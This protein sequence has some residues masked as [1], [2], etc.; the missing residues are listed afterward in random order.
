[1][2]IGARLGASHRKARLA[3]IC[4]HQRARLGAP[5]IAPQCRQS[6]LRS[7]DAPAVARSEEPI[8]C[9]IAT[10]D[11]SCCKRGVHAT[12]FSDSPRCGSEFAR[13][14]ASF[15]FQ[16]GLS[17]LA[18]VSCRAGSYAGMWP[19]QQPHLSQPSISVSPSSSHSVLH[20]GQYSPV[21]T[22]QAEQTK[23]GGLR[24]APRG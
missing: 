12:A 2:L 14:P 11:C 9:H 13:R 15:R 1:M 16:S 3:Y 8:V 17:D 21:G 23:R 19:T 24:L 10:E 20:T 6:V 7:S 4:L 22:G 18:N 5:A